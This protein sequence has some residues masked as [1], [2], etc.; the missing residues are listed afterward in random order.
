M[1]T[2]AKIGFLAVLLAILASGCAYYPAKTEVKSLNNLSRES[3]NLVFEVVVDKADETKISEKAL[4][5]IQGLI[6]KELR[7]KNI[8]TQEKAPLLTKIHIIAYDEGN[9]D[10]R[11]LI[12]FGA[13]K[14][15]I[16]AIVSITHKEK[17]IFEGKIK[18][19]TATNPFNFNSFF[20]TEEGVQK[21]FSEEV[22]SV[23]EKIVKNQ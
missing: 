4:K 13:G 5:E 16:G 18:S 3:E 7:S 23:L 19:E 8:K 9:A 14:S 1:K 21:V 20:G 17:T 15:L 10:L 12:G 6:L 2:I 22:A 11:F